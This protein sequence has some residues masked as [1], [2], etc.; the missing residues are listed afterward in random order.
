[1]IMQT[2]FVSENFNYGNNKNDDTGIQ[3]KDL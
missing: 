2:T 1:M 3:G